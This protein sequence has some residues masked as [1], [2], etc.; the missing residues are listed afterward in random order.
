METELILCEYSYHTE[1][2][3]FNWK[4]GL[5]NYFI[6]L[7]T[8]GHCVAKVNHQTKELAPGDLLLC[9]PGD[10][11][12]L[13]I[14]EYGENQENLAICSGDYFIICRGSWLDEWWERTERPTIKQLNDSERLLVLWK[15]MIREKH[16]IYEKNQEFLDYL[17]RSL[18]L[19]IDMS[20]RDSGLSQSNL[21]QPV[22]IM[23]SYI[24]ENANKPIK[25]ED[26]AN[27]AGFSSSR[28]SHLFKEKFGK[29]IIEYAIDIRL[30]TAI[31][32]IK[33]S[34]MTLEQIAELSGFGSYTYFHRVFKKQHGV[35]PTEWNR[36]TGTSSLSP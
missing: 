8:E 29:T 22:R 24:E 12:E 20:I 7:Q 30:N 35:S 13:I 21:P 2:K 28:A 1:R 25:V 19:S 34:D 23:K 10:S 4:N 11:C 14:D 6:R 17:T 32:L 16:R 31:K 9:K 18:C 27:H 15:E 36:G 33:Y 26:V 5:E 3:H